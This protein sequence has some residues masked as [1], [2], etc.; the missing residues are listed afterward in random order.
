MASP[1]PTAMICLCCFP[2]RRRARKWLSA[3]TGWKAIGSVTA[4]GD[5]QTYVRRCPIT[6]HVMDARLPDPCLSLL[7]QNHV[8]HL[9]RLVY[10][11]FAFPWV[12]HGDECLPQR[13]SAAP[14]PGRIIQGHLGTKDLPA[15]GVQHR[16]GYDQVTRWVAYRRGAKVDDRVQA[17]IFHQQI[18][19]CDIAMHPHV[20]PRPGGAD[21]GFPD[22]KG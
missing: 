14:C 8:D 6:R 1:S 4:G 10:L 18:A 7:R 21:G 9:L 15:W 16:L 13:P 5:A 11:G 12:G 17:S 3:S 22:F 20:W 2:L 19:C